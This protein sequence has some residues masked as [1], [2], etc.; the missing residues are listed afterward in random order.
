MHRAPLIDA[1]LDLDARVRPGLVDVSVERRPKSI[2]RAKRR[3]HP[4]AIDR[5]QRHLPLIA[6]PAFP[7]QIAPARSALGVVRRHDRPRAER[8]DRRAADDVIDVVL[9]AVDAGPGDDQRGDIRGDAPSRPV[10]LLHERRAC[11][12]RVRVARRKGPRVLVARAPLPYT[13]LERFRDK[14][15]GGVMQAHE[16]ETAVVLRRQGRRVRRS[17]DHRAQVLSEFDNGSVLADLSAE[18]PGGAVTGCPVQR[19]ADDRGARETAPGIEVALQ[20]VEF[21][22]AVRYAMVDLPFQPVEVGRRVVAA[23]RRPPG[24]CDEQ[25]CQGRVFHGRRD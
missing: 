5:V 25:T 19:H 4:V 13:V 23:R 3:L 22:L 8:R 15:R 12:C 1:V 10:A 18:S 9:V 24:C 21:A 14:R 6:E 16:Y 20:P 2:T 11:K 17:C 7:L